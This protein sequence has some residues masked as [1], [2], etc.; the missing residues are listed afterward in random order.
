M[1]ATCS[2][3]VR[4]EGAFLVAQELVL[5]PPDLQGAR[6]GQPYE[7][8]SLPKLPPPYEAV[9]WEFVV[10]KDGATAVAAMSR[11]ATRPAD[12]MAPGWDW[13]GS[14][15]NGPDSSRC[16]FE[17]LADGPSV[18]FIDACPS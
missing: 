1:S 17:G 13:N 10:T 2:V 4:S 6:I 9:A 3:A 7:M 18:D 8:L 15:W 12:R 16:G 5:I 14:S 11:D